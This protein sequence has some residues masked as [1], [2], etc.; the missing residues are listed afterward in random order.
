M[1]IESEQHNAGIEEDNEEDLP[2]LEFHYR[3]SELEG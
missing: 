1:Y 2:S 3:S